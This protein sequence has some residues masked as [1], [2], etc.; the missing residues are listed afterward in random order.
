[1]KIFE[2]NDVSKL[3]CKKKEILLMVIDRV[4]FPVSEKVLYVSY[5]EK[6]FYLLSK[7]VNS[8]IVSYYLRIDEDV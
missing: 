3:C 6:A 4:F 5:W 8:I 1:M 2:K 7:N